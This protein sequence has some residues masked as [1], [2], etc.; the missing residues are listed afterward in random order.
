MAIAAHACQ[1]V[2][3]ATH[4]QPLGGVGAAT[5][6]EICT[7]RSV[8]AQK[9]KRR[10]QATDKDDINEGKQLLEITDAIAP[11]LAAA[12]Y[13]RASSKQPPALSTNFY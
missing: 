5:T 8:T 10:E 9:L 11:L 13:H 3:N 6:F 7:L 4:G 12:T 1:G 2:L